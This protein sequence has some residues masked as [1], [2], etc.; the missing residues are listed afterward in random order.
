MLFLELF[1]STSLCKEW[2]ISPHDQEFDFSETYFY[3]VL[4]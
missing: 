1:T 2:P 4:V 3:H